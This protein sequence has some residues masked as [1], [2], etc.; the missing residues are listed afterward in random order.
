MSYVDRAPAAAEDVTALHGE[1][2]RRPRT[3]GEFLRDNTEILRRSWLP[4]G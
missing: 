2:G 4:A 1:S 3:F